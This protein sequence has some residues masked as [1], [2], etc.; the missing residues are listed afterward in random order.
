M[1]NRCGLG[2]QQRAEVAWVTSDDYVTLSLMRSGK[3]HFL[4]VQNPSDD[5]YLFTFWISHSWTLS[6]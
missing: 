6:K 4:S 2:D 1:G 3:R 5:V